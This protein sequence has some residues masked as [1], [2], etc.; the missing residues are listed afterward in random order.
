M[1]RH[2][3]DNGTVIAG[4]GELAISSDLKRLLDA[5]QSFNSAPPPAPNAPG[6]LTSGVFSANLKL[7]QSDQG[8]SINLDGGIDNLSV[9]TAQQPIANEKVAIKLAATTPKD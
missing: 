2:S 7:A 3:T 4:N 6:Q 9:T 1:N 8:G 5:L